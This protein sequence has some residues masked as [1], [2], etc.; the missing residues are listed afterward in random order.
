MGA[1]KVNLSASEDDE[2]YVLCQWLDMRGVAYFA[3]QNGGHRHIA[4][5]ARLK[6]LG[7]KRGVPDII[8]P[9]MRIAIELKR[10]SGGHLSEDQK[11]WLSLLEMAGWKVCVA[12]GAAE[13]ISF[14]H[15]CGLGLSRA[16]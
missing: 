16:P 10:K 2:Q 6:R 8:V 13:A 9:T 15:G 3:V 4:T 12:R 11:Q 14:L 1:R 7:V 5:A